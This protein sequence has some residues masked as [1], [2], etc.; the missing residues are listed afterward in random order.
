M[1][2][3]AIGLSCLALIGGSATALAGE[4]PGNPNALG[5][6]PGAGDQPGRLQPHRQHAI[7]AIAAARRP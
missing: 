1:R 2:H 6:Q 3:L 7:Q 5:T 4:C